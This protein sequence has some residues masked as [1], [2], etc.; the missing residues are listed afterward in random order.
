MRRKSQPERSLQKGR[1]K[2][3]TDGGT[4]SGR[5]KDWSMVISVISCL[6]SIVFGATSWWQAT[7]HER[8]EVAA[9]ESSAKSVAE[10][11]IAE[12]DSVDFYVTSTQMDF[13][14]AL[15]KKSF[16]EV[17]SSPSMHMA[18]GDDF[19]PH[20]A[21]TLEEMHVIGRAYPAAESKIV[22]CKVQVDGMNRTR[23]D[24]R[25]MLNAGPMPADPEFSTAQIFLGFEIGMLPLIRDTC[26]GAADELRQIIKRGTSS[27]QRTSETMAPV[28]AALKKDQGFRL[29]TEPTGRYRFG[30]ALKREVESDAPIGNRSSDSQR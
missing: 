2:K 29:A 28:L 17:L 1:A 24:A 30:P 14:E 18:L 11:R 27:P 13:A 26:N 12:F 10:T 20:F 22:Q 5:V 3:F 7:K 16:Q 23:A 6:I 19:A 4:Y 25:N 9:E 21:I 8:R 15:M